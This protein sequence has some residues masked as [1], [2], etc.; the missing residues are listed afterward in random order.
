[1]AIH[2]GR[3]EFIFTL[4]GAAAVAAR[5]ARAATHAHRR[6]GYLHRKRP[7]CSIVSPSTGAA[8]WRIRLERR[9]QY[10]N[11]LSVGCRGAQ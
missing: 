3:R 8:A 1:M 4:G 5:G 11:R 9:S 10:P 7:G 6:I 2:I